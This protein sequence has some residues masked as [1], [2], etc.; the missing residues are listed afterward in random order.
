MKTKGAKKMKKSCRSNVLMTVVVVLMVLIGIIASNYLNEQ[1]RFSVI[2][3]I[4]ELQIT[5]KQIIHISGNSNNYEYYVSKSKNGIQEIEKIMESRGFVLS[6][7]LGSAYCYIKNDNKAIV[8]EERI[9]RN[10][11]MWKVPIEEL[12]IYK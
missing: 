10:Y 1:K 9:Y 7:Q 5:D 3:G 11:I 2:K 6:E 4:F 12:S 8:T